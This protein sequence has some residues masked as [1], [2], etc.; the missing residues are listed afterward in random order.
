MH[1]I[2]SAARF[3]ARP[4][5]PVLSSTAWSG[6]G[7][8]P[9]F[10]STAGAAPKDTEEEKPAP[11]SPPS[12]PASSGGSYMVKVQERLPGVAVAAGVMAC[13]FGV[14]DVLGHQLLESQ[15]VVA[16]A[17]AKSPVSGIPVS[18]LMGGLIGNMVTLPDAV[19]PGISFATKTILRA[20]VVCVGI[21][22]RY[23]FRWVVG[24]FSVTALY[25]L[26]PPPVTLPVPP[27]Y[28]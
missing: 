28:L 8:W 19:K 16:A 20:G 18:I 26:T 27:P 10:F 9:V 7:G 1:L 21:K 4:R 6:P 14:A 13:S 17:G 12:P 15:G 22:L 5:G 24:R 2:R 25:C 23:G 11:P 3:T